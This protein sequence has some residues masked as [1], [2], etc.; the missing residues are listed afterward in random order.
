[1]SIELPYTSIENSLPNVYSIPFKE[2]VEAKDIYPLL[3][4]INGK[5]IKWSDIT[6]VKDVFYSYL[7]IANINS[8]DD[9]FDIHTITIPEV[10]I[11]YKEN[12]STFDGNCIF[13]FD[14]NTDLYVSSPQ[15]DK[16]YTTISIDNDNDINLY[17]NSVYSNNRFYIPLSIFTVPTCPLQ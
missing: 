4:F 15:N 5:F 8:I 17:K 11:T 2:A 16:I 1:M 10:K 6:L 3:I 9:K 12:N 13:F 7:I 14:S